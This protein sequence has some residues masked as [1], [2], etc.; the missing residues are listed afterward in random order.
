TIYLRENVVTLPSAKVTETSY[1][2]DSIQRRDEYAW[3]LNKNH[4]VKLWNEKRPGDAPGLNFSPIGYW[5]KEEVRKR[6][7]KKRLE[8]QERD[9]YIDSKFPRVRVS[10][11]T[12]LKG[13]SLDLF[14]VRYRPGYQR[15]RAMAAED[16]LLYIND[17]MV[18]FRKGTPA[19]S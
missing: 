1:Q 15:C 16:M 12:G 5:S 10:I 11:L 3:L 14:M 2:H 8:Q 4:P 19:H 7:L 18:L 17:K 6:R 13:D 9:Y